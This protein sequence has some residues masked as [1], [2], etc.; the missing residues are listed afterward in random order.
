MLQCD[1]FD[2]GCSVGKSFIPGQ[3]PRVV[4]SLRVVKTVTEHPYWGAIEEMLLDGRTCEEGPG[5]ATCR[6]VT[7]QV[8][9]HVVLPADFKCTG[10]KEG[11]V[12]EGQI[13]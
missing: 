6:N 7:Q 8:V 10:K 9:T 2:A 13:T 4:R 1:G 5:C 11:R 3:A 12:S